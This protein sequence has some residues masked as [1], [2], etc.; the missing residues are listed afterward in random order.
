[1]KH[2]ILLITITFL[3]TANS[4][5][6]SNDILAK[7]YF[8]KAQESYSNGNMNSSIQNLDKTV[9]L[10]GISNPKIDALYVK[11][12][13]QKKNYS[14]AKKH[15]DSYFK[16]ATEDRSEYKQMVEMATDIN[17]KFVAEKEIE[18]E[19]MKK[20]FSEN[21]E[22]VNLFAVKKD[23]LIGYVNSEKK[24]I[25]DYQYILGLNITS[26]KNAIVLNKNNKFGMINHN[27]EEIINIEYDNSSRLNKSTL[28]WV[29]LNQE[30]TDANIYL[31]DWKGNLVNQTFVGGSVDIIKGL[32]AFYKVKDKELYWFV[33]HNLTIGNITKFE[34]YMQIS[35]L[36][37]KR[38]NQ[39]AMYF[40]VDDSVTGFYSTIENHKI[41]KDFQSENGI[42][43]FY[44]TTDENGLIGYV[45]LVQTNND[46][47]TRKL[48][49]YKQDIK[50][51]EPK[52]KSFDQIKKNDSKFIVQNN[53]NEKGIIDV[54]EDKEIVPVIYSNIKPLNS[55][56]FIVENKQKL[57]GIYNT[58]NGK[59]FL[60]IEYNE[61]KY[62][63][64][65][66]VLIKNSSNMYGVFNFLRNEMILPI[67]YSEILKREDRKGKTFLYCK[68]PNQEN[69][70][71]AFKH[72]IHGDFVKKVKL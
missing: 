3:L 58:Y 66:L 26:N 57:K 5:S 71:V 67:T 27:N 10:L 11:A 60:P 15:L 42:T 45:Y 49:N 28:R 55:R 32:S 47:G 21:T 36:S 19:K 16:K 52:Y 30:K 69:E 31:S 6:Q 18:N 7:S 1:M 46:D 43:A 37:L 50:V 29:K 61:V 2:L 17:E 4:Y 39:S 40:M 8:L 56:K 59:V 14:G 72:T 33:T 34:P 23:N 35:C 48:S 24:L 12:Y 53:Q 54:T 20:F 25:I 38:D 63:T 22:G 68:K 41:S 13:S 70:N 64:A 51:V 44:K 62:L 65:N 9:E